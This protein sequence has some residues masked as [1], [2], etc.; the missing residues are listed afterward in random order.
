MVVRLSD[1]Q[2]AAFE[3]AGINQD[4]IGSMI[5]NARSQGIG[6]DVI[7]NDLANRASAFAN[8][9]GMEIKEMDRKIDDQQRENIIK[10]A[11]ELTARQEAKRREQMAKQPVEGALM[12]DLRENGPD[13]AFFDTKVPDVAA[14]N[15]A[16]YAEQKAAYQAGKDMNALE[17]F[18]V[19]TGDNIMLSLED[20]V[21]PSA[22]MQRA[23]MFESHPYASIGGAIVGNVLGIPGKV[24]G[25]TLKGI[26][27]LAA[28]G[29]K[30]AAEKRVKQSLG[31][32]LLRFGAKTAVDAAVGTATL[33][34]KDAIQA[35]SKNDEWRTFRIDSRRYADDFIDGVGWSAAFGAAGSYVGRWRRGAR[36]AANRFGGVEKIKMLQREHQKR[37]D[38]G[39][40][41]V[42]SQQ[43]F[44]RDLI[45]TLGEEDQKA[46]AYAMRHDPAFRQY[47]NDIATTMKTDID[48]SAMLITKREIKKVTDDSMNALKRNQKLG[49]TDFDT[50]KAG[51]VDALG[52]SSAKNREVGKDLTKEGNIILSQDPDVYAT[53][54]AKTRKAAQFGDNT[55]YEKIINQAEIGDFPAIKENLIAQ[56]VDINSPEV[57]KMAQDRAKKM[58][59]EGMDSVTD[60]N[61]MKRL[62]DRLAS[63]GELKKGKGTTMGGFHEDLNNALETSFG[64]ATNPATLSGKFRG[65]HN[66]KHFEDV[67]TEAHDFGR[68]L[69]PINQATELSN[70]LTSH[71]N[72]S[73]DEAVAITTA[74]KMGYL[75]KLKN[76]AKE[77]QDDA[78]R[79]AVKNAKGNPQLNAMLGGEKGIQEY[80]KAMEPEVKAAKSLK[81]IL[82]SGTPGLKTDSTAQEALGTVIA[83]A[84]NSPIAATNRLMRIWQNFA[85]DGVTPRVGEQMKQIME[86]PTWNNFNKFINWAAKDPTTRVQLERAVDAWYHE[87][88]QGMNLGWKEIGRYG[89]Q[90]TP[91]FTGGQ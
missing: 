30:K 83:M 23:G 16:A 37:I 43:M 82:V 1:S 4:Q 44:Q 48:R 55:A 69:D 80:M 19:A 7:Y 34:A 18:T 11:E 51:L 20:Y 70:F 85:P 77:G 46:I 61:D 35:S 25:L 62:V 86:D 75:D 36:N 91:A 73:A 42:E 78:W 67:M 49:S 40:N 84:T 57:K 26:E 90:N 87:A 22:E 88:A 8:Y 17:A 66:V 54:K 15:N 3:S 89:T 38:A 68:N 27:K 41:P 13:G 5:A 29:A 10:A 33:A 65:Y 76:L 21:L 64:D 71:G 81:N 58:L 6:D 63:T 28:R 9:S 53:F 47:F 24:T 60:V 2:I 52:T 14:T 59:D 72:A 50:S 32:R 79:L 12:K 39:M 31:K 74:V 56:G 45:G